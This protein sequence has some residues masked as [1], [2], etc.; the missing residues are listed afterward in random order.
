[1]QRRLLFIQKGEWAKTP[2]EEN[3]PTPKYLDICMS[4]GEKMNSGV[5]DNGNRC[6]PGLYFKIEGCDQRSGFHES[7]FIELPGISE[8][9][10][11]EHQHEAIIYQR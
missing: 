10:E 4:V 5:D 11:A 7:M 9:V 3:K 1:M 8:E 6:L 2:G